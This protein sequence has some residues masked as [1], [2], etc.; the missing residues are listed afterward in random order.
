MAYAIRLS[1]PQRLY[2]TGIY[3]SYQAK[4]MQNIFDELQ[5]AYTASARKMLYEAL[6]EQKNVLSVLHLYIFV[7]ARGVPLKPPS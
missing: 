6:S 1:P 4:R 5:S 3:S 7:V 2:A